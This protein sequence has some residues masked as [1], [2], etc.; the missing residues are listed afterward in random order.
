MQSSTLF[1][2]ICCGSLSFF[3]KTAARCYSFVD[4]SM[5]VFAHVDEQFFQ[6]AVCEC[7]CICIRQ[8][9]KKGKE[10]WIIR[11]E[12]WTMWRMGWQ[13][14]HTSFH[15]ESVHAVLFRIQGKKQNKQIWECVLVSRKSICDLWYIS[16][17]RDFSGA[18]CF[19]VRPHFLLKIAVCYLSLKWKQTHK[20]WCIKLPLTEIAVC[21]QKCFFS[22][23]NDI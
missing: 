18:T 16:K 19:A 11:N 17:Q 10:Y 1:S 13:L 8:F 21:V 12:T 9:F 2:W 20:E 6:I 23:D 4:T 14:V 3:F 22:H 15:I 5:K 7:A